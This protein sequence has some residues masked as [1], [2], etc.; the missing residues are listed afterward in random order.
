M[1]SNQLF[2]FLVNADSPPNKVANGDYSVT[3]GV[4]Q[5]TAPDD[6]KITYLRR[7]IIHIRDGNA[8][9]NADNYGAV[10]TLTNGVIVGI[11][12][13]AGT[14]QDDLTDGT[15]IKSAAEWSRFAHNA[16][17]QTLGAGSNFWSIDWDMGNEAA[18]T[19][20]ELR[21]LESIRVTWQDDLTGLEDHTFFLNGRRLKP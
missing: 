4:F 21:P 17:P 13:A 16:V 3:P 10:P 8:G 14:L 18:G 6:D 19:D 15:P 20:I 2:R 9:F 7:M 1:R 5:Y 11:Y 12:D